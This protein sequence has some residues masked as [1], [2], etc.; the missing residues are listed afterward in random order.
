MVRNTNRD[1]DN[2]RLVYIFEL[3]DD[4]RSLPDT[5][6][7]SSVTARVFDD[8]NY[9]GIKDPDEKV[10][11]G[12]TFNLAA[13]GHTDELKGGEV[14]FPR[15][16]RKTYSLSVQADEWVLDRNDIT[17]DMQ[18]RYASQDISIPA[19]PKKT[20]V[21]SL[22]SDFHTV[23]AS[24]II[25]G[26][27]IIMTS[28]NVGNNVLSIPAN[29]KCELSMDT[30]NAQGSFSFSDNNFT[31]KDKNTIS[32]IKN[33]ALNGYVYTDKNRNGEMDQGEGISTEI[34][35]GKYKIKTDKSGF[36]ELDPEDLGEAINFD[37]EGCIMKP[38]SKYFRDI[39]GQKRSLLIRC[40]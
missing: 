27:K 35:L 10:I 28:L 1:M 40:Q 34:T 3:G 11:E 32:M 20:V 12:I 23:V 36:F 19:Y 18:A 6:M 16:E 26:P 37:K 38:A 13:L 24:K 4:N 17:V 33:K 22:T 15:L 29:N 21:V 9:N 30:E 5:I 25:C 2:F 14:N 7:P 39:I 31:L 8:K